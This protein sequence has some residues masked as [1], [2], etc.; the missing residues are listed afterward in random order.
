MQSRRTILLAALMGL[1]SAGSLAARP[2]APKLDPFRFDAAIPREFGDWREV[3]PRIAQVIDPQTEQLLRRIYSQIVSRTYVHS[4]G[5]SIMLSLAYGDDQRGGLTAHRPD[6]CYPAQGFKVLAG[7][8]IVLD[9]PFGGI[10]ARRLDTSFGP[11]REPVT[12]WFNVGGTPIRSQLQQRWAEIRLGFFGNV[13]DGLLFRVSSIDDQP[14]HAYA[15]QDRFV[16][17]LLE[18]V[19]GEARK[20][21]A[22]LQMI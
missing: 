7:N 18:A 4:S 20:R 19:T 1:S 5:Y 3:K 11:R 15:E 6:V 13:P 8:D 12:Y 14:A 2:G 21:I 22:G 10:A 16:V 9:T 17:D